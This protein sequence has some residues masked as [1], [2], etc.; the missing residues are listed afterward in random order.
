MAHSSVLVNLTFLIVITGSIV[1]DRPTED[2]PPPSS[3][4]EVVAPVPAV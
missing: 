1:L 4:G 3:G 2:L